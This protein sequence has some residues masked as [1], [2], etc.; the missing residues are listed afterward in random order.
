MLDVVRIL[1]VGD[2]V[3]RAG[4]R[5]VVELWPRLKEEKDIHFCI[6]NAENIGEKGSG[7]T[8]EALK[9]LLDCGVDVVTGGDHMGK[10]RKEPGFVMEGECLLRPANYVNDPGVGSML[11]RVQGHDDIKIG[12]TNV[13][14]NVFM[15]KVPAA[16]KTAQ[17]EVGKLKLLTDI[18]I[19]DF[20]AEASSEKV[21]M[22]LFLDGQVSAVVGTHTH[23]QTA[24]DRILPGQTAYMTDLG[25]TGG[26]DGVIGRKKENVILKFLNKPHSKFEVATDDIWLNGAIIDVETKTG[27]AIH[28]ERVSQSL[29]S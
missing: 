2:V 8:S 6:V 3:G 14:G 20:H 21:A 16:F 11:F 13:L 17:E 1:I 25:M 4:E 9:N 26:R 15:E 19:I 22:G 27:R 7:I 12:V 29:D 18:V 23:V 24:D 10:K 5:A 28:I